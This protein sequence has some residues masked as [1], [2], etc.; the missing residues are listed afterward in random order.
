M[1]KQKLTAGNMTWSHFSPRKRYIKDES[2][3]TVGT[4]YDRLFVGWSPAGRA[5][6]ESR[7]TGVEP[8]NIFIL[9][10]KNVVFTHRAG[11]DVVY[12][13]RR[14]GAQAREYIKFYVERLATEKGITAT[15][16]E[17]DDLPTQTI[18]RAS[19]GGIDSLDDAIAAACARNVDDLGI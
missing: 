15:V 14:A 13:N 6:L 3:A 12:T 2:G 8:V 19:T 18:T 9:G 11:D 16:V 10:N 5:W 17:V 4:R 7:Y 1:E